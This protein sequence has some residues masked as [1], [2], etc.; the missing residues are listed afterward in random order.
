MLPTPARSLITI[1]PAREASLASASS[2]PLSV[3][4]ASLTCEASET[5]LT[6]RLFAWLAGLGL[7]AE[8]FR[9][10]L[11]DGVGCGDA[12]PPARAAGFGRFSD[13]GGVAAAPAC[14]FL[15]V[16]RHRQMAASRVGQHVRHAHL[17]VVAAGGP[18]GHR[19]RDRHKGGAV[20]KEREGSK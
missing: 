20:H 10:A 19:Q 4:G 1:R 9:G 8:A 15:V 14:R 13:F 2:E 12:Q 5:S 11:S 16:S 18:Q 17:P 3:M 7:A 6:R